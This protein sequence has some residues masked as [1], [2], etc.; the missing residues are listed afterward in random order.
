L[1]ITSPHRFD[2]EIFYVMNKRNLV[3]LHSSTS[4]GHHPLY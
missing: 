2:T 4:R 1:T 3:L